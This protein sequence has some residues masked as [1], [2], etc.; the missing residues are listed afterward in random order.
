MNKLAI[1]GIVVII[2]I[3]I[4]WGYHSLTSPDNSSSASL[5]TNQPS[6]EGQTNQ[7]INNTSSTQSED[8]DDD[9]EDD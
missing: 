7:I 3:L 8:S 5:S 4:V 6:T 9:V 1:A 2:S